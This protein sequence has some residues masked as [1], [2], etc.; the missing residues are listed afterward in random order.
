MKVFGPPWIPLKHKQ[1]LA[2]HFRLGDTHLYVNRGLGW[3]H[4]IRFRARPELTVFTLR[5]RRPAV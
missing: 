3:T 4:R 2:G 5:A 1:F